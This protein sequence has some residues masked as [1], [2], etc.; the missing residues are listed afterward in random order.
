MNIRELV[1]LQSLARKTQ[2]RHASFVNSSRSVP[3]IR[4]TIS[5]GIGSLVF[6]FGVS[7]LVEPMAERLG[8]VSASHAVFA[9]AQE[10]KGLPF[11]DEATDKQLSAESIG[12]MEKVVGLCEKA[13]REGLDDENKK[14]ARQLAASTLLKISEQR[15]S[16]IAEQQRD[17]RWQGIRD[18][19]VKDLEK[20]RS[21]DDNNANVHMMRA[22]LLALPGGNRNEAL[23]SADRAIKLFADD[24]RELVRALLLRSGLR[25]DP[26]EQIADLNAAVDLEQ[27]GNTAREARALLYLSR[28]D[29]ENASKDF[30]ELADRDPNNPQTRF[31][32]AMALVS[33][34]KFPEALEQA[35]KII[36]ANPRLTGPYKL[37]AQV[38]RALDQTKEAIA[39]LDTAIQ[40]EP[41]D[42]EAM[43]LRADVYEDLK[44]YDRARA[45]VEQVLQARPGLPAAILQ[46]AQL[47]SLQK[48]YDLAIADLGQLLQQ[49]PKNVQLRV[50]IAQLYLA[51]GWPRKAIEYTS[52]ILQE[53]PDNW[54]AHRGRGDAYLAIGKHAEAIAD[55]ETAVKLAPDHSGILNNFAWVL[56]TTP[57]DK[58]RNADRAI[59]FATRACEITKYEES[60]I[61]STLAAGYAEKG[62]FETAIKWSTKAVELGTEEQKEPL[63]KE[64]DS[65]QQKKAWRESQ[66]T[67]EKPNPPELPGTSKS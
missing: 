59:E 1:R 64:L 10:Q 14:F 24:K 18:L 50:Q 38:K 49:D 44:D 57:D 15:A 13:L 65:Y 51:G 22:R 4:Q 28:G 25:T 56:A 45:D 48:R 62:D 21:F 17:K 58:L 26:Q 67:E 30:A 39:D 36:E 54:I 5:F 61:L 3:C 23:A 35:T 53:A 11:L 41:Q 52:A 20:A 42:L 31:A 60:H 12:D 7:G 40:L 27:E 16:K 19:A 66:S 43:L 9:Q 47:Y 63:R 6:A 55:F 8:C 46:R 29:G 2:D 34:K 33:I 37:R 32:Y